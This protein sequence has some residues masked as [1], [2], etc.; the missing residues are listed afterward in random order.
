MSILTETERFLADF[1]RPNGKAQPGWLGALR[2]D[3]LGRFAEL[4]FPTTEHEDWRFTNV[5]SIA[6]GGYRPAVR[7][8][9]P[10]REA[11]RPYL[12][13]DESALLVFVNG[14]YSN[15]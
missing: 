10:D 13:G 15:E 1:P 11:I 8:P 12:F 5:G 4:G 6:R 7:G 14:F 9:A 3:A 2:R